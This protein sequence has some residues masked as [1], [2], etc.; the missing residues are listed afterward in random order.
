MNFK[1]AAAA[2]ALLVACEESGPAN[3]PPG[4]PQPGDLITGPSQDGL[5]ER[6]PDLCQAANYQSYVGQSGTIVPTLGITREYRVVPFGGIVTQ[7]YNAGRLN[8]WLSQL[9]TIQKVG[10]G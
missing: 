10:C 8:F 5:I 2:L 9:G 6:E 4:A 7:E 3:P 1:V